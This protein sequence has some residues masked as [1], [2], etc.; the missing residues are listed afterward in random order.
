VTKLPP[1][2]AHNPR[3]RRA[4]ERWVNQALD[5]ADDL[6]MDDFMQAHYAECATFDFDLKKMALPRV[7]YGWEI[8]EAERGNIEPLRKR[9]PHLAKFLCRPKL[10]RG[11]HFPKATVVELTIRRDGFDRVQEAVKDVRRIRALWK[12]CCGKKNRRADDGPSAEDIAAGRWKGVD[13]DDIIQRMKKS[14]AK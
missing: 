3:E 11:K 7:G 13:V 9:L 2:H 8:E 14:P 10:R 12:Q 6:E 4:M 5:R 1:W